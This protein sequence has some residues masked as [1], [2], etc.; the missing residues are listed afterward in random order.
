M[1][2]DPSVSPDRKAAQKLGRLLTASGA[3]YALDTIEG[4]VVGSDTA[5]L[6]R[7]ILDNWDEMKRLAHLVHDGDRRS[8]QKDRRA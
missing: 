2:G 5:K 3:F 8:G 1:C 6:H 4:L 7:F